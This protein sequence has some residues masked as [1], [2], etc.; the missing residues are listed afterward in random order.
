M[1]VKRFFRSI[2]PSAV[3]YQR[4]SRGLKADR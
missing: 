2:Q 1:V 3:G 4:F